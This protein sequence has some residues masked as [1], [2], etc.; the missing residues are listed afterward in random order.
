MYGNTSTPIVH[1]SAR[2]LLPTETSQAKPRKKLFGAKHAIRRVSAT[3]LRAFPEGGGRCLVYRIRARGFAHR[4]GLH[5]CAA[6]PGQGCM[7]LVP[8]PRYGDGI[9]CVK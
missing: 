7:R 8:I 3:F 5:N 2:V 4:R 1:S 6:C 9:G